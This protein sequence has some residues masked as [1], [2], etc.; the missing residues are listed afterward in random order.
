MSQIRL[1]CR[2]I[3]FGLYEGDGT[4]PFF[5][6]DWDGTYH[7]DYAAKQ[8]KYYED[9]AACSAEDEECFNRCILDNYGS[10]YGYAKSLN[11]LTL[12]SVGLTA[13]S[14][15]AGDRLRAQANR[16]LYTRGGYS[17]G[18]RQL[19]T[20]NQFTRINN[21]V[22]VLGVGAAA[23]QFTAYTKCKLECSK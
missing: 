18:A 16:N 9:L 21:A 10:S 17:D 22:L 20:Y 5:G 23:Y 11:P 14:E 8:R 1:R 13:V 3:R 12:V 19:R 2:R 4:A 6:E 15:V 7:P